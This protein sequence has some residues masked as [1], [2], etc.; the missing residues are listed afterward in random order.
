MDSRKANNMG[1]SDARPVPPSKEEQIAAVKSALE[2][3]SY[4]WRTID[5]IAEETGLEPETIGDLLLRDLSGVVI[6]SRVPDEKGR[7]LYTTREHYKEKQPTW[8]R[9]L[10]AVSGVV[11]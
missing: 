11:K 2:S 3:P 6:K 9:I 8:N 10:S 5:G 7:V 1:T 4:N